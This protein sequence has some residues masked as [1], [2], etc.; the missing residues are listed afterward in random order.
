MLSSSGLSLVY[1]IGDESPN[2]GSGTVSAATCNP[3][4]DAFGLSGGYAGIMKLTILN[5]YSSVTS[6]AQNDGGY[7][8]FSNQCL[9][10]INLN[11]DSSYTFEVETWY[12]AHNVKGYI[13]F[14]NDD[15]LDLMRK[16]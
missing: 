3:Q 2:P 7:L 10:T 9:K 6:N 14:N 16:F 11:E 12:N 13:D 15:F 1:S 8:D 4:T 5:T